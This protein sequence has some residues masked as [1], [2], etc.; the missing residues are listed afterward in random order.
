VAFTVVGAWREGS[1]PVE[2][3]VEA[4][5]AERRCQL[6][7]EAALVVAVDKRVEGREVLLDRCVDPGQYGVTCPGVNVRYLTRLVGVTLGDLLLAGRIAP[8]GEPLLG[9]SWSAPIL[10]ARRYERSLC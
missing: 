8:D 1:S 9:N 4:E 7:C 10:C 3:D 6:G 5:L 2:I